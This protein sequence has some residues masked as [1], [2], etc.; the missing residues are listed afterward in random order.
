[1]ARPSRRRPAAASPRPRAALCW[2][3]SGC[4]RWQATSEASS[5]PWPRCMSLGAGTTLVRQ[6]SARTMR[7][8]WT[9]CTAPPTSAWRTTASG[10]S[11]AGTRSPLLGRSSRPSRART[12]SSPA[13]RS[14]SSYTCWWPRSRRRRCA[15]RPA[16]R[17]GSAT[18]SRRARRSCSRARSQSQTLSALSAAPRQQG[19]RSVGS[20]SG[21]SAPWPRPSSWALWA[22]LGLPSTITAR[23]STTL[24]ILRRRRRPPRRACTLSGARQSGALP[25]APCCSAR[26]RARASPA[27]CS[28]AMTQSSTRRRT[29]QASRWRLGLVRSRPPRGRRRRP[30]RRSPQARSRRRTRRKPSPSTTERR[31]GAPAAS[32]APLPPL[33][34]ISKLETWAQDSYGE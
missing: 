13:W 26:M 32:S 8:R 4:Q 22:L 24:S 11:R 27:I 1:M 19:S 25:P 30:Q 10:G 20:A 3:R 18:P 33:G 5:R 14:C 21:R 34:P 15:T 6:P 16:A 28:C 9:S 17:S 12:Q 29:P 7:Y 2:T 23:A 31:C